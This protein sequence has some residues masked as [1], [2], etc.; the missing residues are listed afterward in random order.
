GFLRHLQRL[1]LLDIRRGVWH[2]G[3][4]PSPL[5]PPFDGLPRSLTELRIDAW[6]PEPLK[7][8]LHKLLGFKP[9]VR[10]RYEPEPQK[11]SWT[12]SAP[13]AGVEVWRTYGSLADAFAGQDFDTEYAAL[14]H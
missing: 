6:D 4:A 9:E 14:Q 12:I 11:A 5:E 13:S 7:E 8:Q 3:P 2:A 10:Q 1:E